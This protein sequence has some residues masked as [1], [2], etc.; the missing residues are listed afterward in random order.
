MKLWTLQ[1]ASMLLFRFNSGDPLKN[2]KNPTVR[3][4]VM[5]LLPSLATF[6]SA[7]FVSA[8]YLESS[9]NVLDSALKRERGAVRG[10]AFLALGKLALAVGNSVAKPAAI[11]ANI[12]TNIMDGLTAKRIKD[13]DCVT[14]ALMCLGHVARAVKGALSKYITA[15]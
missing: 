3:R 4:A 12:V 5:Q 10:E 14:E 6:D 1:I 8:K 2:H 13:N 9:I 7:Q 11:L 15:R